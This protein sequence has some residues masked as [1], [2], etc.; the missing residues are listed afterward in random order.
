MALKKFNPTSPGQRGLFQDATRVMRR[1][2]LQN[3]A[4]LPCAID[5]A[6]KDSANIDIKCRLLILQFMFLTN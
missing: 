4:E 3:P 5:H 2:R 6:G 1:K